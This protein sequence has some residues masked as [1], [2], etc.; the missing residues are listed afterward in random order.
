MLYGQGSVSQ[1]YNIRSAHSLNTCRDKRQTLAGTVWLRSL[2]IRAVIAAG[3]HD[4][5]DESSCDGANRCD[6]R[7]LH[8]FMILVVL[9]SLR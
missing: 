2:R 6:E 7:P 3:C 5:M 4:V 8:V 9:P 1:Q